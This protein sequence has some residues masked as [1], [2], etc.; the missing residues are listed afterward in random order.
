MMNRD[1][2]A[3]IMNYAFGIGMSFLLS[4]GYEQHLIYFVLGTLGLIASFGFAWWMNHGVNG[5]I[6]LSLGRRFFA[7]A[8]AYLTFTGFVTE[9]ISTT[10]MTTAMAALPVL[11]SMWGYSETAGPNLPGT[12]IT[13][14]TVDRTLWSPPVAVIPLKTGK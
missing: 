10:I 13:D 12:T 1:Q 8:L 4:K 6:I 11:L 9:E 3:S 5:D 7:L 2:L 14:A